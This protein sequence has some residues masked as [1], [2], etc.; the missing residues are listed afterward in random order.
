MHKMNFGSKLVS[1]E[2]NKRT[3]FLLKNNF[4]M[5][6]LAELR[7]T[8]AWNIEESGQKSFVTL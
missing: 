8:G 1:A 7:T 6:F 5:E 3:F 4:K 2:F